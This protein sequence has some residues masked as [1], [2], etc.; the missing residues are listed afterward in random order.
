MDGGFQFSCMISFPQGNES[1]ALRTPAHGPHLTTTSF[2][3]TGAARG[4]GG[5]L[6]AMP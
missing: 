3:S 5:A 2:V 6:L 1:V 4:N